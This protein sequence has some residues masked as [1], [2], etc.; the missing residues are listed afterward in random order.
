MTIHFCHWISWFQWKHLGN[1]KL[2]KISDIFF[3]VPTSFG[4]SCR[5]MCFVINIWISLKV[6]KLIL[7]HLF[8]QPRHVLFLVWKCIRLIRY[9]W[10][11]PDFPNG[12]PTPQLSENLLFVKIFAKNC[13][14]MKEIWP[15]GRGPLSPPLAPK[16]LA[17]QMGLEISYYFFETKTWTYLTCTLQQNSEVKGRKQMYLSFTF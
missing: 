2:F 6:R 16:H 11:I 3:R 13:M 17:T 5:L 14:T 15:K 10:Q 12:P 4:L 1:S 9:Q 7:T 8:W